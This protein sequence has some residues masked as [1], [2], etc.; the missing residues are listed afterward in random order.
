MASPGK[1]DLALIANCDIKYYRLRYL[2]IK[3]GILRYPVK[4]VAWPSMSKGFFFCDLG[5]KYILDSA[6]AG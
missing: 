3:N 4:P 2:S 5:E 6:R 1:P